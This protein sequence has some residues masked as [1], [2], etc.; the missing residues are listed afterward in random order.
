MF[1]A[2]PLL[3]LALTA[4][5]SA[6]KPD[7][8]ASVSTASKTTEIG[9]RLYYRH[10]LL[11]AECY[12]EGGKSSELKQAVLKETLEPLLIAPLIEIVAYYSCASRSVQFAEK[13]Y[14]ELWNGKTGLLEKLHDA[15]RNILAESHAFWDHLSG[16]AQ[17]VVAFVHMLMEAGK[18]N[19]EL[20]GA[21]RSFATL[22][23]DKVPQ[24]EYLIWEYL[25]GCMSLNWMRTSLGEWPQALLDD[26]RYF[27]AS[28]YYSF[29]L[30]TRIYYLLK[31]SNVERRE[32]FLYSVS[33]RKIQWPNVLRTLHEIEPALL[34]KFFDINFAKD[35][36]NAKKLF[37]MTAH[38][39]MGLDAAMGSA[40]TAIATRNGWAEPVAKKSVRKELADNEEAG[41]R[42]HMQSL[43]P[44]DQSLDSGYSGLY[45]ASSSTL[46]TVAI[47]SG[48]W[49]LHI[50][51]GNVLCALSNS[52]EPHYFYICRFED[53]KVKRYD[54]M[55]GNSVKVHVQHGDVIFMNL[56]EK[57]ASFISKELH[58]TDL[59][60]EERF[61]YIKSFCY[62][63]RNS[64]EDFVAIVENDGH[65]ERKRSEVKVEEMGGRG[66]GERQ[67][68][69]VGEE[70]LQES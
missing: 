14:A 50:A 37:E 36:S 60:V 35:S 22:V 32:S 9:G 20:K 23:S 33:F 54:L 70:K 8:A 56:G 4:H 67:V 47:K 41:G 68:E 63:A 52:N 44:V 61:E 65:G 58:C 29:D 19:Q 38:A 21:L 5:L 18:K 27:G 17:R 48:K 66:K 10:S 30:M 59:S 49:K 42:V 62:A 15:E 13:L 34:R 51:A 3:L 24:T 40:L 2:L 12:S 28:V 25:G 69:N 57:F 46:K 16:G 6:S 31:Q 7:A 39:A 11:P 55:N 43:M 64:M 45:F 53:G 26:Q 1:V